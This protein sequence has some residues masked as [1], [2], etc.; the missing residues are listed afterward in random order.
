MTL[1]VS[2]AAEVVRQELEAHPSPRLWCML[3]D[4]TDDVSCYET[5]WLLSKERSAQAQRHW[6]FYFYFRK[7]V[8]SIILIYIRNMK[9]TQLDFFSYFINFTIFQMMETFGKKLKIVNS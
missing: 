5:A 9:V 6:G 4:A 2:Q 1:F 8:G 3:G 7:E